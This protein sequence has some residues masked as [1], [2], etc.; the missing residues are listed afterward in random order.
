MSN[1]NV[2]GHS[3]SVEKRSEIPHELTTFHAKRSSTQTYV[4]SFLMVESL[5]VRET[6]RTASVHTLFNAKRDSTW[7]YNFSREARFHYGLTTFLAK[8]SLTQTYV[9]SF[10]IVE[11]PFEGGGGGVELTTSMHTLYNVKRSSTWVYNFAW[12]LCKIVK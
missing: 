11:S 1:L 3:F 9:F 6:E 4:S 5:L 7:V 10:L 12:N 2:M 8:R